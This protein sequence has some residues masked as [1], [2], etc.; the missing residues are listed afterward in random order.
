MIVQIATQYGIFAALFIALLIYVIKNT[1]KREKLYQDLLTTVHT[2]LLDESK[3]NNE[4]ITMVSGN[5]D[6][7][8]GKLTAINQKVD[9]V[10]KKVDDVNNKVDA[11]DKKFDMLSLRMI[12][13]PN[14]G[15]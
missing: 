3:I 1:D 13:K 5:I 8:D 6:L 14:G 9:D 10:E 7:L 11:V 4:K 12:D 2:K 15:N